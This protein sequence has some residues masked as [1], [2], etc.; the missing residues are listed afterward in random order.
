MFYRC[1]YK[2]SCIYL[3]R[4][5]LSRYFLFKLK[6]ESKFMCFLMIIYLKAIYPLLIL[7]NAF[8]IGDL[9]LHNIRKYNNVLQMRLY[10]RI[11][12]TW[13]GYMF[14]F[15]TECQ[16]YYAL[17]EIVWYCESHWYQQLFHISFNKTLFL[18]KFSISINK[19]QGKTLKLTE[20]DFGISSFFPVDR[21]M[22]AYHDLP[23]GGT[24]LCWLLEENALSL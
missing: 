9:F 15:E 22:L 19:A 14:T 12:V 11:L 10:K 2:L 3:V 7:P 20:T 24:C 4:Y 23:S 17:V 18:K 1:Y 13:R 16:V 8:L 5:L 6:D 21:C